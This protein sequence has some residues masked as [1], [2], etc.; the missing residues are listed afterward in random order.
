MTVL[1]VSDTHSKHEYLLQAISRVKNADLMIHLGDVEG[2]QD[3]I[4]SL[5]QYPVE[6][7]AG[8]NDF[9]STLPREKELQIGKYKVLLTHGHYLGVNFSR[10]DIK[11]YARS[12][13]D[14]IV[15]FGHTHRP[16]ID[17][18]DDV[19]ALNPGSISYPR[20]ENRRPS[21]MV[22]TTDRQ[23]EAHFQ[24]LYF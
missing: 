20:Q 8:N 19:I 18:D 4:R 9:W 2:A 15:M 13:G 11:R 1:I 12:L 17:C 23:G 21:C 22:M 10:N 5:V 24:I 7:V 3:Y 16:V 14:D 6:F